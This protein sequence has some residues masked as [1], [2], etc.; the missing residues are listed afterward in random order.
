[1][2]LLEFA[3][4]PALWLSLFVLVAGSAW[5]VIAI[6]RLGTEADLSEPRSTRRFAGALRGIFARM[7]PGKEFR[8]GG[9]LGVFG[10]YF[11]H[12]GLAVIVFGF[13]PHILFIQRLTGVAW[14]PLPE[15]LVYLAVGPTFIGLLLVLL[16]RLTHPVLRL[17]S[18]FDDYFSWFVV[19]LPLLTGMAAASGSYAQTASGAAPLYPLPLALHLL[20]VELLFL[21]LPFGKLAHAFLVFF[22]R[23]VTGVA[24]TRKGAAL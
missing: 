10:G 15:A 18:G 9:K 22:S 17:L 3:R 2:N 11:Y 7:I 1:M 23:G 19:F 13:L 16:E 24:L 21:W 6:F 14:P 20:S 4:G 8:Q 5:R 12:L